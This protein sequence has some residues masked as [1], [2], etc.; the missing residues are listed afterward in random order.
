MYIFVRKA[1]DNDLQGEIKNV[2]KPWAYVEAV[3]VKDI[4]YW[5]VICVLLYYIVII[6]TTF[7]HRAYVR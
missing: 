6:I 5:L 4:S 1:W 3:C 2:G 7:M